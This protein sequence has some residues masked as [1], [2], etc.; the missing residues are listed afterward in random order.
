MKN[1]LEKFG[2]LSMATIIAYGFCQNSRTE[3]PD[4]AIWLIKVGTITYETRKSA[5][6]VKIPNLIMTYLSDHTLPF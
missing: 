3:I 5:K 1:S 2:N 6:Y 4:E